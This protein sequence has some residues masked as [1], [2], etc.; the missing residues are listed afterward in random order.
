[1]ASQAGAR[2]SRAIQLLPLLLAAE[3]LDASAQRNWEKRGRKGRMG[4]KMHCENG[5]CAPRLPDGIS[6]PA[7]RTP[8]PFNCQRLPQHGKCGGGSCTHLNCH[9]AQAGARGLHA[10]Q[11]LSLLLAAEILIA[12][13]Q[14]N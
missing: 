5:A 11:L 6:L 7:L 8:S 9:A 10:I 1:M 14:R 12:S 13:A 2:G 3:I 4:G